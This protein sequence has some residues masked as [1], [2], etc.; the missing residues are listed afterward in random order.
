MINQHAQ[1][2]LLAQIRPGDTSAT[3]AF[4][5]PDGIRVE[6]TKVIAC[7]T[8]GAARAIRVFHDDS[9][10]STFD[11]T[12]ALWWDQAVP[13]DESFV[14]CSEDTGNGITLQGG[15]QLAVRS[16]LASGVTFSI[17]GVAEHRAPVY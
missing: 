7:N 1:A 2:A 3:L 11:E 15:G 16:D 10:G 17:Y 9:G 4:T 12:T 8:S 6:V 5:A 14:V 13:A